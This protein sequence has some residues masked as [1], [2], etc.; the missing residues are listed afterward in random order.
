MKKK[1]VIY[2]KH[3]LPYEQQYCKHRDNTKT[4]LYGNTEG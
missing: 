2:K 4:N 1:Y 3:K